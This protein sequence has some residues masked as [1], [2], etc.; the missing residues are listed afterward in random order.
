MNTLNDKELMRETQQIRMVR[1]YVV[2][3]NGEGAYVT[4]SVQRSPPGWDEPVL[5]HILPGIRPMQTRLVFVKTPA[6]PSGTILAMWWESGPQ[7]YSER[8]EGEPSRTLQ[9]WTGCAVFCRC[10]KARVHEMVNMR[11]GDDRI[12]LRGLVK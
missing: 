7:G 12:A 11:K 10:S 3:E 1:G 4:L 9:D 6:N 8:G 2:Q 5:Q